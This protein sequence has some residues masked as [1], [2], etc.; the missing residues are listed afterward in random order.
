MTQETQST[1]GSA[2]PPQRSISIEGYE[3]VRELHRG[4]QGVI[5]E[6]I[7]KST[8]RKVAIKVLLA[9]QYATDS[10]K[11]RFE[12]EIELVA[13]LKHPNI[14]AIF[15]S[16]TTDNGM[17]FYVMDYVRGLPLHEYVRERKLL[18]EETLRLFSTVCYAV[19]YAHQRGVIHRDLKPSNVLVDAEGNPKVLDFGLAKLLAG[20]V[21][22]V[23]SITQ[24]VIGTLPYMSPEQ[25]RGR[26]GEIDT[27]ADVY[28]LGVI[29]YELLTGHFPYPV[30][31][32][33]VEVLQHIVETPPTPPTRKW[34]SDSGVAKRSA[35][36]LRAGECPIDGEVQTII[37]KAL[38]KECDR[39][40]QSAGELAR[41]LGHYLAGEPIDAR[42]DSG[43]YL[44]RLAIR[45]YRR[46]LV[47]AL[48]ALVAT[49]SVLTFAWVWQ[50]QQVLEA[51]E[52]DQRAYG[53]VQQ[54]V[55]LGE[56]E[57]WAEAEKEYRNAL[58][59]DPNQFE[60]LANLARLKKDHYRQAPFRDADRSWLK[61]ALEYCE[62]TLVLKPGDYRLWNVKAVILYMLDRADEAEQ[63]CRH[64]LQEQPEFYPATLSLAKI[65]AMKG[66]LDEAYKSARKATELVNSQG[67][68]NTKW[69]TGTWRTLGTIQLQLRQPDALRSFE[70][71][72]AC[73]RTN[74]W[75]YLMRARLRLELDGYIDFETALDDAKIANATTVTSDGRIKRIL[76][77]AHLRNGDFSKAIHHAKEAIDNGDLEAVNHLIASIAEAKRGN[78]DDA[79]RWYERA[80]DASLPADLPG[81]DFSATAA[82]GVLW[83]ESAGQLTRLREEAEALLNAASP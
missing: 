83:F 23:V 69:A 65:L 61:E 2:L 18:L 79:R 9:G 10:A 21:E 45:R 8:K 80:E 29:L 35:R 68:N 20:P 76:A 60:A 12:R 59:I 19:Q 7:Q 22:A 50:R 34:T 71:A 39:R 33:I 17:Q 4:G 36:R 28:A 13:Q 26:P 5:Y 14:I 27:R 43:W 77:L 70:N 46:R 41:D 52:R 1:D 44:L 75:A 24:D 58:R 62:R 56:F 54:G 25:A 49:A 48:V 3:I 32:Q 15:D 53:H 74:E 64:A 78:L 51:K 11:R 40:Y 81:K 66:D 63:A 37:L 55:T 82:R 30:V 16:G 31:G 72:L 42:R 6:A 57:W 73:E 47:T 38:A 67:Y